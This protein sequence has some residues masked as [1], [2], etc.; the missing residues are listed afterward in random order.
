MIP[1]KFQKYN[2]V[3]FS[4]GKRGLI[5]LFDKRNK[6]YALKIKNPKSKANNRILNEGKFLELLNKKGM[7]PELFEFSDEFVCYEFV[8]GL[9]LKDFLKLKVNHS[10][11]LLDILKQ[12]EIL[13]SLNI[14][15]EEM[16]KPLKN[17]II[18]KNKAVLID[19]ERCHFSS[20]PKNVN[21]FK[22]FLRRIKRKEL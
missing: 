4:K 14:N 17:I 2:P 8:D 1:L 20:R 12:C 22:E 13:D 7:G 18:S 21:Q 9:L 19:F 16:H 3:I 6:K 11:V 10:K 15:K 5:Y